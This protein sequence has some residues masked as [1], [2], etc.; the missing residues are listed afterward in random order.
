MMYDVIGDIH[1]YADCLVRL[2]TLLGYERIGGVF[3]HPERKVIFLGDFIDRGP[4]IREVLEI[5]RPMIEEGKA[6]AVMGNHE[7]NALAF[8]T[9]DRKSPGEF[10]RRHSEKNVR[11]YSRTL[12]QVPA[13]ELASYLKWFRTLPMWLELDGLRV[14]HACWETRDIQEI[15]RALE[16]QQGVTDAFLQLACTRGSPLFKSVE[17]VLK[18]KELKLPDGVSF[19]DPDG[20]C[21][22]VVRTRWYVPAA[23]QTVRTYAFQAEVLDC[24]VKIETITNAAPEPYPASAKPV[25][26]G[27]YWLC[28]DKPSILADNVACVDYGVA[29]GGFLCAYR[30]SG[31]RK[32][33]N[34]HFVWV[35]AKRSVLKRHAGIDHIAQGHR[36]RPKENR[37][38]D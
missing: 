24:D 15:Q 37:K 10:L 18:G 7:F 28:A 33:S 1:G 14:V 21:R 19:H 12:D 5:V 27:H 35:P 22:T 20:R 31:E 17:A 13:G 38:A 2:L 36:E 8:H 30:W 34:E 9:E 26:I 23:G 16:Q 3:S 11:Q 32:L 6:L 4:N 25:F 29:K